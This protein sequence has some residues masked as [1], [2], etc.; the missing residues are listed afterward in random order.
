LVTGFLQKLSFKANCTS[1]GPPELIHSINVLAASLRFAHL[2]TLS[3]GITK[4]SF[5]WSRSKNLLMEITRTTRCLSPNLIASML[6]CDSTEEAKQRPTNAFHF[7]SSI[8]CV[9]RV[10]G[11][12]A[13]SSRT[14]LL[15]HVRR[16]GF[17]RRY[18]YCMR[19]TWTRNKPSVVGNALAFSKQAQPASFPL[20]S[21][22]SADRCLSA[23][24]RL[25]CGQH[26]CGRNSAPRA[27]GHR[28]T[29]PAGPTSSRSS[30]GKWP[31]TSAPR[32]QAYPHGSGFYC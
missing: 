4:R 5:G 22:T 16:K 9:S 29:Q 17:C 28:N 31:P 21:T 25:S 7:I 10:S 19:S 15:H 2:A 20:L 24:I 32:L 14:I 27:E 18:L 12:F 6:D 8:F 13:R 11:C 26:T 23:S 1:R 3:R 30:A